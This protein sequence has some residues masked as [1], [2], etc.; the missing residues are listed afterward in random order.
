M[1]SNEV[2]MFGRGQRL[3]DNRVAKNRVA[4][5]SLPPLL[6]W[7]CLFSLFGIVVSAIVLFLLSPHAIDLVVGALT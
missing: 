5:S 3:A 6:V 1:R 2:T 7:V 4:N